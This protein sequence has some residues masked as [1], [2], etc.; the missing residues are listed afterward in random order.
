V[1]PGGG[2]FWHSGR[3]SETERSRRATR[4]ANPAVASGFSPLVNRWASSRETSRQL[5]LATVCWALRRYAG[6]LDE[7]RSAGAVDFPG[8]PKRGAQLL[9]PRAR[10]LEMFVVSRSA[11][12]FATALLVGCA[13]SA[14]TQS[15]NAPIQQ[16]TLPR[17]A[18]AETAAKHLVSRGD[19]KQG[20]GSRYVFVT[21]DLGHEPYTGA[22]D[23]YPVGANGNVA[24]AGE[25]AGSQTQLTQV[26][27]I[28]VTQGGWIYV[29]NA[30]T[31]SIVGF[32]PNSTGDVE[33]SVVIAGSNTGLASPLGLAVDQAGDVYVANCGTRCNYGPPGPT[34]IEE[35]G[36]G[37]NGNVEPAFVISGTNT[38]LGQADGIA[39]DPEGYT[40]VATA[41]GES[42]A[43]FAPGSNGNVSPVR[44]ISGRGTKIHGPDAIAVGPRGIYV[45]ALDR[46]YIERFPYDANGSAPPS[47]LLRNGWREVTSVQAP[48]D[49]LIYAA[50]LDASSNATIAQYGSHAHG[51]AKPITAIS[52]PSTQLVH[53]INSF[54][55]EL[56]NQFSAF[57][58]ARR[59]KRATTGIVP[60]VQ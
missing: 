51:H 20:S 19:P 30:D 58:C 24:P 12:L 56:P 11:L 37:S 22:V 46:G 9:C 60:T 55:S 53:P 43:V 28:V 13:G 52:G 23:Y 50:G 18:K 36:A 41:D 48:G 57:T 27:G 4:R 17:A 35:F 3:P 5:R 39:V 1:P 54:V 15:L 42:V 45:T 38:Q 6:P 10:P 32:A 31:N 33:P 40:Y 16:V 44:V 2:R 59:C 26:T 49:D 7:N 14:E 8:I 21:N 25:I 47:S 29:A 34:S